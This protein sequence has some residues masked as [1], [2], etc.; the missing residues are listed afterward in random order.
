[1]KIISKAEMAAKANELATQLIG[2]AAMW[3]H[4]KWK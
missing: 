1:M 2:C 3:K 4:W